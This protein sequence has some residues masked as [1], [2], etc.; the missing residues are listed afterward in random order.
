MSAST[1]SKHTISRGTGAN[2]VQRVFLEVS[3]I[4]LQSVKCCSL[5]LTPSSNWCT[6]GMKDKVLCHG[7]WE[8]SGGTFRQRN[9]HGSRNKTHRDFH[10]CRWL[11]AITCSWIKS[12][13]PGLELQVGVQSSGCAAQ[14]SSGG[15]AWSETPAGSARALDVLP[16]PAPEVMPSSPEALHCRTWTAS[17]CRA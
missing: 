17:G 11:Q 5:R 9:A 6:G 13:A 16:S 15:V 14:P 12:R 4:D 2:N 7:S 10:L 3:E 1:T 8:E